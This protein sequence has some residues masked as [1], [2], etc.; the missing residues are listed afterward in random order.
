MYLFCIVATEPSHGFDNQTIC[1]FILPTVI[2]AL[3][4]VC[5]AEM[6]NMYLRSFLLILN[7]QMRAYFGKFINHY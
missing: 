5:H 6:A 4:Y 2:D 7:P 1:I 3:R